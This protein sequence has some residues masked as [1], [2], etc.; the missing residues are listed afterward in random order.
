MQNDTGTNGQNPR[1]WADEEF[2]TYS[3]HA[4]GCAMCRDGREA[5]CPVATEL[6]EAYREAR[7]MPP[8]PTAVE[9]CGQQREGWEGDSQIGRHRIP[10]VRASGHLGDHTDAF[11]EVFPETFREAYARVILHMTA[12]AAC[13]ASVDACEQGAELK[14]AQRAARDRQGA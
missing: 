13:R 12:C 8:A 3:D 5:I 1:H 4:V 11:G 9:T 7:R 6:W 2:R 10:C 14:T